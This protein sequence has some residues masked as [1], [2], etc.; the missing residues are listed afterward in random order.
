MGREWAS[1]E[2]AFRA[3]YGEAHIA[4]TTAPSQATLLAQEA[5]D[6]GVE[7][8]VAV[9]GDGTVNEVVNGLVEGDR[10]RGPAR[11]TIIPVGSGTDFARTLG[12]PVGLNHLH[13]ILQSPEFRLVDLGKARFIRPDHE[14]AT[15]YFV[16]ILEAGMGAD[17]VAKVNRSGKPL[18]GRLAFLWA[19][20]TTLPRYTNRVMQVVVDDQVVADGPLNSVILANGQYYGAGL[21]PA[22]QAKPDDG[23]L[24]I[25][26]FG[27]V[28]LGEALSSLGKLRRGEHLSHPKVSAF[29]GAEV[30][31]TAAEVVQAE[32]DGEVIGQLPMDVSLLPR[33][34]PVRVL[35][36]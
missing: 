36:A 4:L 17:V 29:Q 15:R 23:L 1:Q 13:R 34:L 12:L 30:M 19:I 5:L 11:L 9:G 16:N 7:D 35:P 27:D 18:G 31:V 25:I 10:L 28:S 6:L 33:R 22:P 21:H 24:E 8:I 2:A 20:L 14:P 3:T 26:L 32:M